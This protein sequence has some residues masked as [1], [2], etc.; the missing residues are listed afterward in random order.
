MLE[1]PDVTVKNLMP[2]VRAAAYEGDSLAAITEHHCELARGGVGMSTVA[3]CCVA[4]DGL[5]FEKQLLFED[6]PQCISRLRRFTDAVHAAA[7]EYESASGGEGGQ[8]AIAAQLTHGGSFADRDVIR[9]QLGDQ[10]AVQVAPSADVF[11]PAGIDF[12]RAATDA[13]VARLVADFAR[14]ARVCSGCQQLHS[15]ALAAATKNDSLYFK[16]Q[17]SRMH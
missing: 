16:V 10:R 8:I 2:L 1:C 17:T 13:D 11:N 15:A 7:A 5:S 4:A 3:Y 12:P 6:T 14:A 9:R